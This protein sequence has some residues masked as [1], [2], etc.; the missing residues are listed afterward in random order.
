MIC[1]LCGKEKAIFKLGCCQSCYKYNVKKIYR[2]KDCAK[3]HIN[4]QERMIRE[5][6]DNQNLSKEYL[7]EKYGISIQAVY[8]A[9]RQYCDVFYVRK[10]KQEIV[11]N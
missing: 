5:F 1:K 3:F 6:L 4:S 7:A 11:L 8:L 2:M 9:L 10:D